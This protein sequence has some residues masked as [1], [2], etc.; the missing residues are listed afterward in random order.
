MKIAVV[1]P[2]FNEEQSIERVVASVVSLKK[3][4]GLDL[5]AV[6]VDDRSTDGSLALARRLDCAV[7][8]LPINLGIGGAVQ[9]G[10]RFAFENGFDL[11]LQMD[12]DGQHP[13]S[14]IP[15]LLA[16]FEKDGLADVAIGSRFLEKEGFQSSAA[17]R[18]GI[19]Y[20]SGLTNLLFGK[21]ITDP[22][23]GFRAFNRRAMAVIAGFYPDKFP[24]PEILVHFFHNKLKVV[25]T[26]VVMSGRL[27]GVSSISSWKSV[28]YMLKVTL[29]I[30][31][32]HIRLSRYGTAKLG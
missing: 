20:F 26:P 12:G 6:V 5:L 17:R 1:I 21:R 4:T 14:E 23:S 10:I 29:G 31:F 11:A 25:E 22:T 19:R 2:C 3:E 9:T 27:G 16:V 15:K 30:L 13:A 32:S 8:A 7:L 18:V 28:Y 24:E